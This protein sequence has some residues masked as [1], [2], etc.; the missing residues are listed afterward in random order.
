MNQPTFPQGSVS[1]FI[2]TVGL[3]VTLTGCASS[4]GST[5]GGATSFDELAETQLEALAGVEDIQVSQYPRDPG[6]DAAGLDG[7]DAALWSVEM[8][9]TMTETA[10]SEEAVA[11]ADA[12]LAFSED[13]AVDG[14]WTARLDAGRQ[15]TLPEDD[16]SARRAMSLQIFPAG[17]LPIAD[18]IDGA[19]RISQSPGVETVSTFRDRASV[20][21]IDAASLA[22]AYDGV[23]S[24]SLLA[25]GGDY[26]TTDGRVQL[27]VIPEQVSPAVIRTIIGQAASYPAADVALV[28]PLEGTSAPSLFFNGVTAADAAAILSA[29]TD[30]ALAGELVSPF[31]I[32]IAIRSDAGDASGFVG[33]VDPAQQ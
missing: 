2:V 33:G 9:V 26:G 12:E 23:S 30:P 32:P 7:L 28:A 22:L 6:A 11:A 3:L 4:G 20:N 27:A 19:V 21:S 10:T 16:V 14:E 5:A 1:R 8:T 31:T 17:D 13:S 24:E 15:T 25:S 18:A 29:L